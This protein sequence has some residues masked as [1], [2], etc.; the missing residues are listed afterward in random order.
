VLA[1]EEIPPSQVLLGVRT[2]VVEEAV[3]VLD[4]GLQARVEMAGQE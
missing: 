2:L 3:V 1:P 4:Q